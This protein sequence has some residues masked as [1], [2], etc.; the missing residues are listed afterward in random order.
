[1]YLHLEF[2]FSFNQTKDFAIF[3]PC[4]PNGGRSLFSSYFF[5]SRYYL[6]RYLSSLTEVNG[7]E[8]VYPF[9]PL[10][11]VLFGMHQTSSPPILQ[12]LLNE[13]TERPAGFAY[14]QRIAIQAFNLVYD[15]YFCT[16][17]F[18]LMGISMQCSDTNCLSQSLFG[19][20]RFKE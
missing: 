10:E 18:Y 2:A 1:M 17:A 14:V 20:K 12:V 6:F 16:V 3:L 19:T 7:S 11:L 9:L 15:S 8:K 13:H 4:L 5:C